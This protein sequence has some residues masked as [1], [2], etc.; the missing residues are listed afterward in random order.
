MIDVVFTPMTLDVLDHV[1]ALESVAGDTHWSRAQLEK[2]L[3]LPM[4]RFFV[5]RHGMNI[6]GYGGY[7]KVGEEA[8]VTNLA[9]HP[10]YRQAGR[11]HDLLSAL[12]ERA[13]EE[14][15]RFATLEVRSS[16]HAAQALY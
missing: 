7:W 12:M 2:E 3:H 11:G 5:L 6:L 16:N 14:G 9:I 8:Q 15:C 4:A 10:Q 13:R 1:A